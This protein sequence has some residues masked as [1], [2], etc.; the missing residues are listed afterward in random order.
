MHSKSQENLLKADIRISIGKMLKTKRFFSK[1][2][3]KNTQK[4]YLISRGG[5][6]RAL[7]ELLNRILKENH[8]R[9]TLAVWRG[10]G[11]GR[12][13]FSVS[14]EKERRRCLRHRAM[15][16]MFSLQCT[17]TTQTQHT[18]FAQHCQNTQHCQHCHKTPSMHN[19]TGWFFSG[20]TLTHFKRAKSYYSSPWGN[21]LT[22]FLC[23]TNLQMYI[24][25]V[26]DYL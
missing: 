15:F 10:A 21:F 22:L 2:S 8:K 4:A 1:I 12:A 23:S 25:T 5:Y 17:A 9:L 6:V 24:F 18:L 11:Q 3:V 16:T 14:I 19:S 7:S 13:I 26:I 20:N